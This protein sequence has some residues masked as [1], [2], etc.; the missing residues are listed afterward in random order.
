MFFF[1]D[2][3]PDDEFDAIIIP[4]GMPGTEYLRS[5]HTLEDILMKHNNK[6]GLIGA[7][8]AA[9]VILTSHKILPEKSPVTSHQSVKNELIRYDY[10]EDDVVQ[11]GNVVTSRG[12]GTAF[13]FTLRIIEILV[14]KEKAE[15]VAGTIVYKK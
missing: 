10:K 8:C 13:D 6:A 3:E 14:G 15:Q 5:N 2:I 7:I 4:G 11:A 1:D 12:A 9:P